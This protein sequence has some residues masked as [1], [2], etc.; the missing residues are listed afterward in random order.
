MATNVPPSGDVPDR[1]RRLEAIF[2]A[3][4]DL[5]QA[6]RPDFLDAQCEGDAK[7]RAEV[8]SLLASSAETHRFFLGPLRAVARDLS[9]GED[10]NLGRRIGPYRVLKTLGEGGMGN[11]YL[12][13][14]A[15]RQYTQEVAIKLM[16]TGF[17]SSPAM[18]VRFRT[19]RQILANLDHPNIARLLDGGVT[20]DDAPYLVMEHV[21]GLPI[22]EYCRSERLPLENRLRLFLTVCAAVEYAHKNLVVHRDIKPANILVAANG[23]PKLLDFGI[24]K[25]LDPELGDALQTRT[26]ERLMTPEYACPEQIRGGPVTTSADVYGLGVLLYE[27]LAGVRPFRADGKDQFQVARMI[28]E[29]EPVPPSAAAADRDSAASIE[30]RRLKGDLDKIALMALRKEPARRYASVGR[31]AADVR[32]YLNGYPIQ[33]RTDAWGYRSGK[34]VRRHKLGVVAAALAILILVG[35]SIGMAVL[36]RRATREQNVAQREAQFLATMFQAATPEVARGRT[37]TARDL[38]DQGAQRLDRELAD[39][40]EVHAAMLDNIGVAYR[41]LGMP[42][43][44]LPI[45]KNAFELNVKT[46]GAASEEAASSLFTYASLYRDQGKYAEAEPLFRQLV[47]IRRKRRGAKGVSLAEALA[48][49]GECLYLENSD[50]ASEPALRESLKIYKTAGPDYGD[51][52][53]DYLALLIERKGR[54]TEAAELLREAVAIDLRTKGAD[55]PDYANTLSNLAS[56]LLDFGDYT[57]AEAKL[58]DA[59]AIRRR[60][61]GND[62][63]DLAYPLNNLAFVLMEQGEAA[64]AEPF[65]Q[66]ELALRLKTYGRAHPE[67]AA[68]RNTLA[69]VLEAKGDYIGAEREFREALDVVNRTVGI[70]SYLGAQVLLNHS[71]LEF[72][73]GQYPSAEREARESLEAL[74]KLGGENTPYVASALVQLAEDRFFQ[75]DPRDAVPM[76]REA[77]EIRRRELP[78]AHPNVIF[79]EVRLGEA[80]VRTGELRESEKILR[81]ALDDVH[82]ASFTLA[83]WRIAEIQSALGICLAAQGE[84]DQAK[85]LLAT[86]QA[87]L[88]SDPHPTFRKLSA[89]SLRQMN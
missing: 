30:R 74:R 28:C 50:A 2:Q 3:A 25:L 14:R 11:V 48:A 88:R 10:A 69:R 60:V 63:P 85:P 13:V 65:A 79:A 81:S 76:L 18:L 16:R 53:R 15:D 52:A 51:D 46:H 27:L 36:A 87:A 43:Q 4:A 7:L 35:G 73:R 49:L 86:S 26:A 37:I 55:S 47:A 62:H 1:W 22:D 5:P 39:Q 64:Q 84:M 33:A 32:A 75:K 80:L 78:A 31:L 82:S 42:D 66:E 59:L 21:G 68:A 8:E 77:V 41:N 56:N 89:D 72:D 34:F 70:G 71:V 38:L 40:P 44:A 23:E 19:E 12:A 83:P 6:E 20:E 58:R 9:E 54:Y 24:A 61:L 17:G 57:Q 29:D 67:I 45:A